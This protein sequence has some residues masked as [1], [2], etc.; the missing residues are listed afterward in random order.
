MVPIRKILVPID[1]SDLSR[2]ALRH[3]ARVA[4]WTSA[5][6]H[7]IHVVPAR[8]TLWALAPTLG[9]HT[10]ESGRWRSEREVEEFVQAVAARGGVWSVHVREGEPMHEIV[11]LARTSGAD[12]IV[13]GT[14]G[15]SGLKRL[16]LG[17]VAEGVLRRTPCPVLTV[18]HAHDAEGVEERPLR[19]LSLIHI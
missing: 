7:A 8:S 19:R 15:R 2:A 13:M 3:A 6:V 11:D 17:S 10:P 14:H 18:A 1:F 4:R 9:P 16:V 5:E 12:L